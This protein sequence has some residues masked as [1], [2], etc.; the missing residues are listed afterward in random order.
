CWWRTCATTWPTACARS[1]VRPKPSR[2]P[3]CGGAR[4]R[5]GWPRATTTSRCGPST[6][7]AA[8][9]APGSATGWSSSNSGTPGR[10]RARRRLLRMRIGQGRARHQGRF[11]G[12][13]ARE[14]IRADRDLRMGGVDVFRLFAPFDLPP[15]V[16]E[17][18]DEAAIAVEAFDEQR[19]AEP[20]RA[21]GVAAAE[22]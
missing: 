15:G 16:L 14:D 9:I 1:T 17:R 10:C 12:L 21:A 2:R 8:S 22:G 11:P 3:T 4:C 6:T 20:G 7:M 5:H 19:V 13:Q 18:G